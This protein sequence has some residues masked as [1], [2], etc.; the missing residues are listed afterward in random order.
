MSIEEGD[1]RVE[2]VAFLSVV[3]F[4]AVSDPSKMIRE[5]FERTDDFYERYAR[6]LSRTKRAVA[7]VRQ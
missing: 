6:F 7:Q 4:L 5:R 1:N 3:S 2:A